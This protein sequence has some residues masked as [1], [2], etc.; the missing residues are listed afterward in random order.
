[1]IKVVWRMCVCVCTCAG[2]EHKR[3]GSVRE[4]FESEQWGV[5]DYLLMSCVSLT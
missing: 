1:M 2:D 5:I 4:M 3:G